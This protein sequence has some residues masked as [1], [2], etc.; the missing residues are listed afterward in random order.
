MLV[1]AS[2]SLSFP[3]VL[4]ITGQGVVFIQTLP[5]SSGL[6]LTEHFLLGFESYTMDKLTVIFVALFVTAVVAAPNNVMTKLKTLGNVK[7]AASLLKPLH[8]LNQ[9]ATDMDELKMAMVLLDRNNDDMLD[10]DELKY[11]FSSTNVPLDL[12]DEYVEALMVFDEDNNR[13][14]DIN[15]MANIMKFA[16]L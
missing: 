11:L 4:S 1:L 3:L 2:L 5:I 8:S 13:M 6:Q 16:N 15:E 10:A 9:E 7:R 14:L 12:L